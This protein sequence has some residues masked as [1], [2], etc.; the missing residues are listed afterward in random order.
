MASK[1]PCQKWYRNLKV[2]G[3]YVALNMSNKVWGKIVEAD[4]EEFITK[5]YIYI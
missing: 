2:W 1:T 4:F 3:Y 5:L